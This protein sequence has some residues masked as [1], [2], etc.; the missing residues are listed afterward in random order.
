MGTTLREIVYEIGGGI[1]GGKA[2]K[3]AQTGGPSGGCIPESLLDI[4]MEYDTLTKAGAMM[5][6]GGLIIMAVSY[7]HL[8]VYKRQV[9]TLAKA[10]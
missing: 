8:D 5:G 10:S 2:F 9:R 6:S 1:P 4:S 7:T 3:A